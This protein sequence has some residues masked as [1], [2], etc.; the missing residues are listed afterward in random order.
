M[1]KTLQQKTRGTILPLDDGENEKF[2]RPSERSGPRSR[3]PR[4]GSG[5]TPG[6]ARPPLS[7]PGAGRPARLRPRRCGALTK[8]LALRLPPGL[9]PPGTGGKRSPCPAETPQ[10]RGR[11]EGPPAAPGAGP[12]A[13]RR[14]GDSLPAAPGPAA[15]CSGSRPRSGRRGHILSP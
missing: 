6:P 4:R 13:G 10:G 9:P 8:A 14:P 1:I 11:P 12:A 15:L 2:P 5:L 3:H 7:P